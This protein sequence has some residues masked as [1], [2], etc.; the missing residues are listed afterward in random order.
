MGRHTRV[1]GECH[2]TQVAVFGVFSFFYGSCL[3]VEK[4][5]TGDRRKKKKKCSKSKSE[6]RLHR[7]TVLSW[8]K[9]RRVKSLPCSFSVLLGKWRAGSVCAACSAIPRTQ[10][11]AVCVHVPCFQLNLVKP[12]M[13][14]QAAGRQTGSKCRK[15]CLSPNGTRRCGVT[16]HERKTLAQIVG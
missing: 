13:H 15:N 6:E 8:E 7:H 11:A 10:Q 9:L 16:G 1:D 3:E 4:A 12:K 14:T 5:C 2:V